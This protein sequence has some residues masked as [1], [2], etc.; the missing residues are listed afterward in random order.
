M[1]RLAM[2]AAMVAAMTASSPERHHALQA[3]HGVMQH[4]SGD[5]AEPLQKLEEGQSQILHMLEKLQNMMTGQP[6]KLDTLTDL[7]NTTWSED[8]MPMREEAMDTSF[9]SY[10]P[11][12]DNHMLIDRANKTIMGWTARAACSFAVSIFIDHIGR[13]NEAKHYKDGFIH[14]YRVDIMGSR[15]TPNRAEAHSLSMYKF[16]IVRNPYARAVSSYSH[17]LETNFAGGQNAGQVSQSVLSATGKHRLGQLSFL[18]FMKALKKMGLSRFS[19]EVRLQTAVNEYK[20]GGFKYD[21]IC[22]LEHDFPGCLQE[23]SNKAGTHFG[24]PP[25]DWDVS[26]HDIPHKSIGGDVAGF[27]FSSFKTVSWA[28]GRHQLPESHQFYDHASGAEAAK[29]VREVFAKDF[30]QYGYDPDIIS[31]ESLGDM[32][33]SMQQYSNDASILTTPNSH[34]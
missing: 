14:F 11:W 26:E 4:S 23:V 33:S 34:S 31:A 29:L 30:E 7:E 8:T 24:M 21:K 20:N 27:P 16:K 6:K 15:F 13:L 18:D 17:Q 10:G 25:K 3:A 2:L 22:K 32:H 19:Q 1:M 9:Y 5:V 28:P 12:G